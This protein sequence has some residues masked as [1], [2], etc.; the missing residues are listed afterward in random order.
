MPGLNNK[1]PQNLRIVPDQGGQAVA[2][3]QALPGNFKWGLLLFLIALCLRIAFYTALCD[4]EVFAKYTVLAWE[5][6]HGADLGQRLLDVS[7]LYLT[8]L[9]G[10][11]KAA[12]GALKYMPLI[13]LILGAFIPLIIY[14]L[15]LRL[16]TRQVGFAAGLIYAMYGGGMILESTLEPYVFVALLNGLAV[17]CLVLSMEGEQASIRFI[18]AAGIL[19]GLSV[20]A[21]PNFLLFVLFA[22]VWVHFAL[23]KVRQ[24]KQANLYPIVYLAAA[25]IVIA[26]VTIRNYVRFNDFVLVTADYGKV[27]F[28]GNAGATTVFIP[29]YLPGQDK[30]DPGDLPV[31]YAHVAFRK[32]ASQLAGRELSPSEAARF[33]TKVTLKD[34][35]EHPWKHVKLEGRK[36]ALFFH[37][38]EIHHIQANH[39]RYMDSLRYPFLRYGLIASLGLLGMAL[40]LQEKRRFAIL[41]GVV[42]VYLISGLIFVVNSRYRAPAVPYL[43]LFAGAVFHYTAAFFVEKRTKALTLTLIALACLLALTHLTYSREISDYLLT[44]MQMY[45]EYR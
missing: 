13:Q 17:Y 45:P 41:Y 21:K 8:L 15:G 6:A 1:Q 42:G 34:F 5:A 14:G 31:D 40:C 29:Q 44:V 4:A 25:L 2:A 9:W 37:N 32:K 38:F 28:H 43:C 12:P 10:V 36:L 19:S 24:F 18:A 27:F 20:L 39:Y 7:P 16:F 30:P 22:C 11:C 23:R 35:K 26:P 3:D 33:W